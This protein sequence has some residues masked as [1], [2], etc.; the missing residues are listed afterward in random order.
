MNKID[1]IRRRKPYEIIQFPLPNPSNFFEGYSPVQ[2]GEEYV[3]NDN[4]AQ[5][6]NL[7]GTNKSHP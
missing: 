5:E 3:D 7:P 2:A 6:F 1:Y 4:Y